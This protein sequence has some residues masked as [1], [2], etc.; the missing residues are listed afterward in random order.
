MN[1]NS[2]KDDLRCKILESIG[3]KNAVCDEDIG[4]AIDRCLMED[5]LSY[6]PLKEKLVIRKELFN[7]FR[8]LDILTEFLEDDEV[9]EIMVNGPYNIYIEK[10]GHVTKTNR[11]FESEERLRSVIQQIVSDCDRRINESNPIVDARLKDGSRVNI[12]LN[13]ISLEGPVITVRKFPKHAFDMDGLIAA[14]AVDKAVAKLL[15]LLVKARYNIFISGGTGS[16]KTTFLNA[17]SDFI[18]KDERII[19]IEDA[20]ELKIMGV[21]NLVRLEAR[22][23]N[24]EGE[25][26]ISIRELIKSSLRMRP[27]RIIVGE[28]RDGAAL[29]MIAA[30]NTGHDGSLSTGHANSAADMLL[31]LESMILMAV[32]MP[33]D[34]IRRQISSAVDIII[35]LGRL[36]DKSRKVLS[37]VEVK[38]MNNGEIE[39]NNLFEFMETGTKKGKISGVLAKVNEIIHMEKLSQAG[40]YEAYREVCGAI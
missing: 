33:I 39:L 1:E 36:R 5:K 32:D 20:A 16:G 28:V 24:V 3:Q 9:S 31:R 11:Q 40:L 18:P 30:M 12:V 35:H 8:R 14:G 22:P 13:P 23:A 25:N 10:N 2:V 26:A 6:I 15:K 4:K 34:A 7:R 19:T 38:G 21:E 29:D 27:D 17:L 37:I